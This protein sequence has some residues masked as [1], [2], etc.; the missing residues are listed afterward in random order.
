MSLWSRWIF[1][2]LCHLALSSQRFSDHRRRLLAGA[3]GRVLELGTGT[4]LNLPLYPQAVESIDGVD[5]N[6]GMHELARGAAEQAGRPVELHEARGE[7]LPFDDASFDVAVS[8]WTLCSVDDAPRVLA[9]VH[10]V[11]KPGGRLLFIEHGLSHEPGVALW[12][13]RLTPLQ[14]RVADGCHLDRDFTA[15]L[16]ASPL[17]PVEVEHFYDTETPKI[18]GYLFRGVAVRR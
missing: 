15:L 2:R 5:P 18:A 9:E 17:E 12:Q 8:T 6:P 16:E 11:L 10:R 13:R 14:R 7:E 1:P 4:G 3:Q